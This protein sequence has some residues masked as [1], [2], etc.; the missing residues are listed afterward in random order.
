M[1]INKVDHVFAPDEPVLPMTDIQGIVVPGFT[2]PHE[3]LL[4]VQFGT[5]HQVTKNFKNFIRKMSNEIATA[6]QTLANRRDHRLARSAT[7][8]RYPQEAPQRIFIA[9]AFSYSGLRRLTP[10]A[11]A[12]PGDAFRQGM[13]SRSAMLGDPESGE[14]SA[15]KWKVGGPG[16]EMEALF[17][18]A[19]DSRS[20]VSAR[21]D[22]LKKSLEQVGADVIYSENGDIRE[23]LKGHEHFGFDDGVSQP[24]I[25]G[26]AS[27]RADD[28]ITDRHIASSKSPECYLFGYPGQDLIWPGVLLLGHPATS[29][30]PL[31]AGVPVPATPEWTRNG[32]FLVF[33][34][35]VQDVGL[36][37]RTLRDVASRSFSPVGRK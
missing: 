30:D 8:M 10:G 1:E 26:R 12:I 4:G 33:R 9:V 22:D 19:G 17:I 36:F 5:G 34:R 25:R 29:P 28:F 21:A 31:V 18:V 35:L 11:T 37:W 32:S 27:S 14:G 15:G 3:T 13:A 6:E 23:D 7:K 2:K 20:A 24:G 16:K